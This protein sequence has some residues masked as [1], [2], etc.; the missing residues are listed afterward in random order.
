M[1]DWFKMFSYVIVIQ[2]NWFKY[3]DGDSGESGD[4]NDVE[5]NK[6]HNI[7]WLAQNKY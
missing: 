6:N 4:C 3:G 1:F 2:F 5:G 7:N